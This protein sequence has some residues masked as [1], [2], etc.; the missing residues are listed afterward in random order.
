M[1]PRRS[2]VQS[3]KRAKID[4]LWDLTITAQDG[5]S[6]FF[7]REQGLDVDFEFR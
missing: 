1:R 4:A 7:D 3:K 2:F 5:M 6:M